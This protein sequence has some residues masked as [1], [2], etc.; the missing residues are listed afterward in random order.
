MGKYDAV[1]F[2]L[3]G[4]LLNT[5]D[6][7]A[8]A[9][10][11]AL[12][13]EGLP[14]RSLDEIRSFVGNG[15]GLLI[16]RSMPEGS[17]QELTD[18]VY[19]HFSEYYV[20]HGTV[21]TAPYDGIAE[22]LRGLKAEGVRLAVVSNKLDAAVPPI[23]RHYFPGLF[24]ITAGERSGVRR[25]P[26]PD[27]IYY[28]MESFGTP[29]ERTVYVGDSD[30]DIMTAR[31]AGIDCVSVSWGFRDRELF[32]SLGQTAIADNAQELLEYLR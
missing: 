9:V 2:D 7:L 11:H 28:C 26:A 25:K 29:P 32:L 6:D 18:K 13:L 24:D 12:A 1:I 22:L 10:N 4:T 8:A 20:D 5:L 27:L 23:M 15:A 31:N 19:A 17:S 30:V 3:D 16:S 21:L 14:Q